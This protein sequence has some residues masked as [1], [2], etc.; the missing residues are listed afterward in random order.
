MFGLFKISLIM[1]I[2]VFIIINTSGFIKLFKVF[3]GTVPILQLSTFLLSILFN[4]L[5][6][7]LT[8]T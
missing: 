4:I 1:Y 5:M 7:S 8:S 6:Y 2:D 3:K